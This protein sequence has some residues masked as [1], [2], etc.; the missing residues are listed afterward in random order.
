MRSLVFAL[1]LLIAVPFQTLAQD[2][3][4]DGIVAMAVTARILGDPMPDGPTVVLT[5]SVQT[6]LGNLA[7]S[8]PRFE[9]GEIAP[10]ASEA[11]D[12]GERAIIFGVAFT[13]ETGRRLMAFVEVRYSANPKLI[14]VSAVEFFWTSPEQPEFQARRL[15]TGRVALTLPPATSY[16]D[17]V[18]RLGLITAAAIDPEAGTASGSDYAIFFVD[19]IARDAT[20]RLTYADSQEGDAVRA[21]RA[22][23][24]DATGWPILLIPADQIE[25]GYLQIRY[26]PGSDRPE[27]ERTEVLLG[28]LFTSGF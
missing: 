17:S 21:V 1:L 24:L 27:E 14:R 20:V 11:L 25:L 28:A 8:R 18:I 23:R 7:I 6:Y 4:P 13:E 26:T 9:P 16:A 19:R 22:V 2:P 10:L 12:T 3:P 15:E 5:D